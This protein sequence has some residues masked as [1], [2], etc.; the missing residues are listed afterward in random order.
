[1]TSGGEGGGYDFFVIGDLLAKAFSFR[2]LEL[3]C[4]LT[5]IHHLKTQKLN[6]KDSNV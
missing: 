6:E 1:M 5:Q 3:I 4:P 2:H